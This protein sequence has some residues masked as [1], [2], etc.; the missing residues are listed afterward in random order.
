MYSTGPIPI[1]FPFPLRVLV[2][3]TARQARNYLMNGWRLFHPGRVMCRDQRRPN[4]ASRA[5]C[6]ADGADG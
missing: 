2:A 5:I 4:V 3:G 6:K 1:R